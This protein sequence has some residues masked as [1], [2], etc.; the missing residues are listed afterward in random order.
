MQSFA[1]ETPDIATGNHSYKSLG[2]DFYVDVPVERVSGARLVL[3]NRDLAKQLDVQLPESDT[4]IEKFI[5]EQFAWFK[6]DDDQTFD[7]EPKKESRAFFATRYQDSDDKSA[8]SA[9]GD[10]RALWVGE[11]VNKTSQGAFLYYDVVVK[12]TGVTPLAW[13]N[14][15]KKNHRDGRAGMTEAVHE[16]IYSLAAIEN[17][18]DAVGALAVIEL[19]FYRDG[20]GEKAAIIVRVGNHMRFAH[21]RYFSNQP[22]QLEKIF[23]YGL[24]RDLH[25]SLD[26]HITPDDVRNYL[27]LIVINSAKDAAKYYDLHAVHGSPTFGNR[28]SNGGSIDLSTFVYLDAHHGK[29]SYMSGGANSLG[30]EWGQKEQFFNLFSSLTDF[31]RGSHFKYTGEIAPTE[32]YLRKFN[33]TFEQKLTYQWLKRLGL[34]ESEMALLSINAK[35]QF[36]DIMRSIYELE[37]SQKF[38]INTGSTQMAAFEPRKILAQT[39]Q[40]LDSFNE[41]DLIWEKLFKVGRSWGSLGFSEAKPFI[42]Q[43]LKSVKEIMGELN[44]TRHTITEWQHRSHRIQ[45]AD[46]KEP[47]G[48]FFYGSERFAYSEDIL[49]QIQEGKD[50]WRSISD[51]AVSSAAKLVDKGLSLNWP[52]KQCHQALN[53]V[54]SP[55]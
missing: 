6:K 3:F 7:K 2:P 33:D 14:H 5:L 23:E 48:D 15:T 40:S 50:H 38:K 41:I 46:R 30:G 52:G 24:K 37:G 47:G 36:Y 8:G 20:Q 21:Y 55:I 28:T 27:D 43:Y 54:S 53:K 19:P 4:D 9:L 11:L 1:K 39:A 44:A 10:G 26:H 51:N 12:G 17:G 32:Y 22:A 31:L 25:L 18:I 29:Y 49:T 45:L 42:N 35:E 34:A 16:F 13:L